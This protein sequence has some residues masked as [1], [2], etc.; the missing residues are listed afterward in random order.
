MLNI[1]QDTGEVTTHKR[2]S[3]R[4]RKAD[5][6]ALDSISFLLN[7][8]PQIDLKTVLSIL[9]AQ[10]CDISMGSLKRAVH[11][12]GYTHKR[13]SQAALE[14]SPI[15]RARFLNIM[16]DYRLDQLIWLDETSKDDRTTIKKTGWSLSERR[17]H[18]T[19]AFGRGDR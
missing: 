2:S 18:I 1:H 10:G 16:V 15:L 9:Q 4:P 8:Y 7:R 14:R 19:A 3:G 12:M 17:A 13:V 11:N 6:A 5:G